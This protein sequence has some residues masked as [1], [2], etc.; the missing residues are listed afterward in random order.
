MAIRALFGAGFSGGFSLFF[1]YGISD[2]SFESFKK[3]SLDPYLS[4]EKSRDKE[5][6]HLIKPIPTIL[7]EIWS[8][9]RIFEDQVSDLVDSVKSPDS[10]D[11][12]PAD[13]A[14]KKRK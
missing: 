6:D 10:K 11:A 13:P 2:K 7:K 5:V 14:D 1:A 12:K 9:R 3:H 4:A 8:T